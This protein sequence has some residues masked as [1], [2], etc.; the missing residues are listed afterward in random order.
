VYVLLLIGVI[1][2]FAQ[3]SLIWPEKW[4]T[5]RNRVNLQTPN[6]ILT[7]F[8]TYYVDATVNSLRMDEEY[9]SLSNKLVGVCN[10]YL[11]NHNA[12]VYSPVMSLCC[13]AVPNLGPTPPNWIQELNHT[14]IGVDAYVGEPAHKWNFTDG[15]GLVHTYYQRVSDPRY[16]FA[17]V[18]N[19]DNVYDALEFYNS[20]MIDF[21][22]SG[23][24]TLPMSSCATSCPPLFV[25]EAEVRRRLI[26][27]F[28]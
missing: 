7:D 2:V 26:S 23:I 3:P 22:P 4:R 20:E 1:Y 27:P 11:V 14:Y 19:Q 18:G 28:Y 17:M 21:F 6:R 8:A 12:Y 9:C 13:L 24:F 25:T 10:W 15:D 16:P 5:S